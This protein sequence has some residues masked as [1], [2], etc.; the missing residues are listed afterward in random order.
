M[1]LLMFNTSYY[2]LK[3]NENRFP[4]HRW[5]IVNCDCYQRKESPSLCFTIFWLAVLS[6]LYMVVAVSLLQWGNETR[7]GRGFYIIN[8]SFVL[9]I[10]HWEF[11]IHVIPIPITFLLI[12]HTTLLP[13]PSLVPHHCLTNIYPIC[14]IISTSTQ[15]CPALQQQLLTSFLMDLVSTVLAFVQWTNPLIFRVAA[16]VPRLCWPWWRPTQRQNPASSPL[17]VTRQCV[18]HSWVVCSKLR[19]LHGPWRWVKSLLK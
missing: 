9:L 15:P 17:M 19:L 5:C 13:N 6:H 1:Y 3:S 11:L 4:C 18:C 12:T 8:F 10:S 2:F 7:P 16:W 14:L